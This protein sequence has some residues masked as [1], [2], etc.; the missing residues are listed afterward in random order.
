[1]WV[2]ESWATGAGLSIFIQ[3][4]KVIVITEP[5]D[6]VWIWRWANTWRSHDINIVCWWVRMSNSG[7]VV[8]LEMFTWSSMVQV[9]MWK[10][11]DYT[12]GPHRDADCNT[13]THSERVR[14]SLARH[15]IPFH[16]LAGKSLKNRRCVKTQPFPPHKRICL[17]LY[18]EM[19]NTPCN[20]VNWTPFG[21][22][23]GRERIWSDGFEE[24]VCER[25]DGVTENSRVFTYQRQ[26]LLQ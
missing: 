19:F 25:E 2:K 8:N 21:G 5:A 20:N 16:G 4:L 1:M 15:N 7:L 9:W 10:R 26:G 18:S 17:C 6:T 14:E 12:V 11:Q 22:G 23:R 3:T 24:C 13:L